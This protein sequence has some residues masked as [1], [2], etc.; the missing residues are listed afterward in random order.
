MCPQSIS[1]HHIPGIWT[2]QQA[3]SWKKVT[4]AVHA[5]GGLFSMQ[6][7]HQGRVAHHS[8][9]AH[10]M[11]AGAHVGE[12]ASAV[13]LPFEDFSF[14]NSKAAHVPPRE[15][16]LED[17]ARYKRDMV[18]AAQYAID[19]AGCDLV[20]I[21][22]ANGYLLDQFHN[23]GTNTRTDRYGGSVENRIRLTLEVVRDLIAAVGSDRV[24]LRLSPH[25]NTNGA[26]LVTDADPDAVYAALFKALSPL[27]LAYLSVTEPRFDMAYTGDVGADPTWLAPTVNMQKFKHLYTGGPVIGAGGFTPLSGKATVEREGGYDAIGYGRWFIS[28]PDLPMR[29]LNGLPL[30]KYIRDTF[31]MGAGW[32]TAGM[33]VGYTDYPTFEEVLRLTTGDKLEDVIG[34]QDKIRAVVEASQALRCPLV[35][36][37]DIG[38]ST[39]SAQRQKV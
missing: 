18:A 22:G 16:S 24:A 15:M 21:H 1:S 13:G 9:S 19:V 27:G 23:S 26:Y 6:L 2:K 33:A 17:I 28:N 4:D 31:Y 37:E 7:W 34:N 8:F 36:Q 14:D 3:L 32:D 38:V 39:N 35:A 29:V 10:P 30:N 25:D 12:S 11:A 5:K 20:E